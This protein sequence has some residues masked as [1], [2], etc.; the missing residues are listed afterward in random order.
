M[1]V[2][3]LFYI[4]QRQ[5]VEIQVLTRIH[6]SLVAPLERELRKRFSFLFCAVLYCDVEPTTFVV[7]LALCMMVC[8]QAPTI[9]HN[10]KAFGYARHRELSITSLCHCGKEALSAACLNPDDTK[11]QENPQ[12]SSLL[13]YSHTSAGWFRS[14]LFRRMT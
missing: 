10:P 9:I 13:F 11:I 2:S 8:V 6:Q 12:R 5:S 7:L 3:W 1:P 14:R 4:S